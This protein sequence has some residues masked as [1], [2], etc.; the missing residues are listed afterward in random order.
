MIENSFGILAARW[1]ILGRPIEFHPAKTVKVVKACVAL[2]N[3]LSCTDA[4]NTPATR[5]IP[6][7]FTDSSTPTGE[8]VSGDWRGVVAG[9]NNLLNTGRL[10][11]ARATRAAV[12]ARNDLKSVFLTPRGL[13]PW[14]DNVLRKG[15]LRRDEEDAGQ[16]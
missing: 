4:A 16:D 1:R 6:P 2:H 8:P 14:Q 9:D 15:T 3:Y 12:S 5:Y 7:S 13:V 11:K 10:S